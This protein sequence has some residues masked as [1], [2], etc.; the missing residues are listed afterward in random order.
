MT[1]GKSSIHI[2]HVLPGL[3]PGGMELAMAQVISKLDSSRMRH[4][5]VCLKGEAEIKDRLPESTAIY[6]FHARPNEPQLPFRLAG[7]LRKIRPDV[8]HA[9]NWGA[10]PDMVLG[11]FFVYPLI[12][13]IYSFHGLGKAGYMPWR[14]RMASKLLVHMTSHL[15]S[16]SQQSCNM[17]MEHWGWPRN[18]AQVIPNG[19]DTQRFY[20][21]NGSINHRVVIGSVGNLRTVKNHGLLL[22]AFARLVSSGIDIELRIAGEGN[23]RSV[24]TALAGS[25]GIS[26][27]L[28]LP[29]RVVDIPKFLNGLDIFVLS[30]NSEQHPNAL[31]EAM[32]CGV[33]SISTRVGCVDDLLD[34]GRCGRIIEPGDEKELAS[35]LKQLI[36]D[37]PL[38]RK[39]S[40]AGL[41][42][43]KTHYSLEV[44][45]KRYQTL[46]FRLCSL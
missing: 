18:R 30:S 24:L 5:I 15:F 4:S 2:L 43:V 17:L 32:A 19:V 13:I 35:A 27:R 46:Y 36:E 40:A 45:V 28:S 29:G 22:K 14:R 10:W 12:P 42:Q 26:D 16:V 9:R 21:T 44:M 31:N 34:N 1:S 25:L 39:L 23:Q 3:G 33:P 7:L 8:I 37:E 38:R 41:D 11:R 20:K 6:C